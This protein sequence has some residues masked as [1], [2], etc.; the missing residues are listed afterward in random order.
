MANGKMSFFSVLKQ[1]FSRGQRIAF[2]ILFILVVLASFAFPL[3]IS[4]GSIYRIELSKAY[5]PGELADESI[6]AP[7]DITLVDN[8]ATEEA[9]EE[10]RL[11]V[12]PRYVYSLAATTRIE[13]WTD[14]F[15]NALRNGGYEDPSENEQAFFDYIYPRYE[16]L[17][18]SEQNRSLILIRD[19]VRYYLNTGVFSQ[20]GVDVDLANGYTRLTAEIP[21]SSITMEMGVGEYEI[22]DLI[23]DEYM[24]NGFLEWLHEYSINFSPDML[25]FVYTSV[26]LL[27]EA[28]VLYD[29][30]KTMQLREEAAAAVEPVTI[31]VKAGD[32][33]IK[34][35]TIVT[36]QQL[37]IIERINS[38]QSPLN[39]WQAIGRLVFL[40]VLLIATLVA[41]FMF[42]EHRYRIASYTLIYL[43]SMLVTIVGSAVSIYRVG[44]VSD[45]LDQ[46][47][48][49]LFV[50]LLMTHLTSRKRF[51]FVSGVYFAAVVIFLPTSDFLTFFYYI[52]MIEISLLFVR[53]GVNRLDMIYQAFYSAMSAVGITL[54][55]LLLEGKPYSSI[56]TSIMLSAV[57]VAVVYIV[58]SILLPVL[59]HV[60]NIPT[61]FRL[62]ELCSTDAPILARL[63]SQAPGTYN[64]V[65]NVSDMS[66]L[67]AKEIGVNA[68]LARVGGLYHDIGKAE[69]PEYFI[70]NQGGGHNI[71]DDMKFTL[72]AAVI[73]SHV[74]LGVEKGKEIGLPQ[75]VIDIIDQH[76]GNDVISYF[77][78]EALKEAQNSKVPY[79]VN[80]E[81]FKYSG[82][83]PQSREAA[84]V[85]LADC[86]EAASRTL[87]KP[88]N[89]RYEKLI[90]SIIVSK[91]N[92]NQLNDSHLT[93]TDLERIKRVFIH[94]ALGRD[95]QRIEYDNQEGNKENSSNG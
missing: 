13:G 21:V 45:Y 12:L 53:F 84:I 92:H 56:P 41:Y 32:Y 72:S 40:T 74:K 93:M 31:S 61:V 49:F 60:F 20:Q 54:F 85:M 14:D 37:R 69:H 71:H 33:I 27:V 79:Q 28:N 52:F 70:E 43:V 47:L 36:R 48:P 80:E 8:E 6:I 88:T 83:I 19:A 10:A 9:R 65:N 26:Y 5:V 11:S 82:D 59:E 29:G 90:T 91:I 30:Q 51:G 1:N 64:H 44:Y 34:Q 67:A 62:H 81:D 3:I 38:M 7:E 16:S 94:E 76:H 58:L 89:Q 95:H 78:N 86:F 46:L 24:Y 35:D 77:Y 50:P 18:P 2:F 57:N 73:K 25:D 15:I 63:R 68:E 4:T 22:A 75:E 66:Y 17:I 42:V 55:F 87:K 23:T 39:I